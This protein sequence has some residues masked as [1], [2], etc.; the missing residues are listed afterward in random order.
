MIIFIIVLALLIAVIVLS[1]IFVHKFEKYDVIEKYNVPAA[2]SIFGTVFFGVVI[3]ILSTVALLNSTYLE[4][5]HVEHLYNREA[6]VYSLENV[7][8]NMLEWKD[9]IRKCA[10]FNSN[11]TFVELY[12]DDPLIGWY[13]DK[14]RVGVDKINLSTIE[15]TGGLL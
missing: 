12:K 2:V 4:S 14:S 15:N 7:N 10:E 11:I 6:L 5:R 1:I 9:T 3:I 13:V 8:N